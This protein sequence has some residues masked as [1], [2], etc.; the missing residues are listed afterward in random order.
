VPQNR[1]STGIPSDEAALLEIVE[2]AINQYKTGQNE[3]QKGAARPMRAH[4][5]C[6]AIP[7]LRARDW[8]GTVSKLST[9]GDG[10]GV[11]YVRIA[12][13][14]YLET[15]NNALS[16]A[17]NHIFIDPGSESFRI[18]SQLHEG[19]KIRFDGRFIPSKTDCIEEISLT[20]NGSITSPE[21]TFKF[22]S[23]AGIE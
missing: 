15:A 23:V 18:V 21:F 7:N 14:I 1:S 5:I 16:D 19:Q 12:T 4:S 3:M 6:H 13:D 11:L 22:E 20:L 8:I 17:F 10:K 2:A 9:N